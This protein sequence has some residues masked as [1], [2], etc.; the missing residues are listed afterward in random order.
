L[1]QAFLDFKSVLKA[2]FRKFDALAAAFIMAITMIVPIGDVI[3]P[4]KYAWAFLAIYAVAW[5]Q[6]ASMIFA[7]WFRLKCERLDLMMNKDDSADTAHTSLMIE[8]RDQP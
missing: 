5:Y 4:D 6:L 7:E 2:V 8:H 1:K 3:I